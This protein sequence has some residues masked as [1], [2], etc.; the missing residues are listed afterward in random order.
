MAHGVAA[1]ASAGKP[2]SR[3][4][5]L[6]L[7]AEPHAEQTL[8]KAPKAQSPGFA[9]ICAA[10]RRRHIALHQTGPLA[11]RGAS[12]QGTPQQGG[13]DLATQGSAVLLCSNAAEAQLELP[14]SATSPLGKGRPWSLHTFIKGM[15]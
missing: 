4:A 14:L 2:N 7:F 5:Q 1:Q 11:A 15:T 12:E 9:D 13:Q 3:A 10:R 8:C 6:A